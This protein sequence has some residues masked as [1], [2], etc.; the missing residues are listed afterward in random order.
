MEF[1][2]DLSAW[3]VAGHVYSHMWVQFVTHGELY[4]LHVYD[5]VF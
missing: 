1:Y 5:S 2:F 4:H 3:D